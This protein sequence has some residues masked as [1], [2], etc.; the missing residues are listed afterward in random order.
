MGIPGLVVMVMRE[1]VLNGCGFG[2]SAGLSVVWGCC[3][4]AEA[5]ISHSRKCSLVQL[6]I[7]AFRII[8]VSSLRVVSCCGD[9]SG[10]FLTMGM[11]I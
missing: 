9:G 1:Y 2:I 4:E 8:L 7:V 5:G 10:W 6:G 11:V 3:A